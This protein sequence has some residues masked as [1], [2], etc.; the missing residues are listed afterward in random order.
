MYLK[1]RKFH[2]VLLFSLGQYMLIISV[3]INN[4]IMSQ[5]SNEQGM[6]ASSSASKQPR[7][8]LKV[9]KEKREQIIDLINK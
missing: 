3:K 1:V 5:A 9:S 4:K 7:A 8:Y 2:S 6:P